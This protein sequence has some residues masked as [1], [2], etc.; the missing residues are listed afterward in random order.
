QHNYQI[1]LSC[2]EL[3]IRNCGIMH[4]QL[5]RS[6]HL[7]LTHPQT[8]SDRQQFMAQLHRLV[9]ARAS[10]Q[11]T[12]PDEDALLYLCV[13]SLPLRAELEDNRNARIGR[14]PLT[15]RFVLEPYSTFAPFHF[16]I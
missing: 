8:F 6:R 11:A 10:H 7:R 14:A 9:S 3:V 5:K 13:F 2:S 1:R 16:E 12:T 4:L 15:I